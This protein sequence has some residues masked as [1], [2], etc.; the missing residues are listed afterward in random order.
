MPNFTATYL[1][2][3]TSQIFKTA[4][5]PATDASLVA[6]ELVTANLMGH[7]SHGVIRIPQYMGSIERGEIV[8][9]SI[10]KIEK[11]TSTT[12]VVDGGNNFGQ[13]SAFQALELGIKKAETHNLS[14]ILLHRCNHVGRLGAYPQQAAMQNFI[15][16]ATA[17]YVKVG[18][19][20]APFG[21]RQGRLGTNPIAYGIPT[22]DDPILADFATSVMAEGKIRVQRNKGGVLPD[23]AVLNSA[24]EVTQDPNQ[25]YGPP[26]GA[27]LPFGGPVGY[28]GF[29]LSL[30]VE[31]L[32]GALLGRLIDDPDLT[33]N[34]VC[35]ILLRP[36][37]FIELDAFRLLMGETQRYVKDTPAATGFNEV[38]LPGEIE[39]RTHKKRSVDGITLDEATWGQILEEAEKVGAEIPSV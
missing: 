21:G 1:E 7:D 17:N 18:H 9:G 19:S 28:K 13:V 37:A 29:A 6:K 10:P 35:F 8:P 15:C 5:A 30:L 36:D 33:G 27:I 31:I 2:T 39:F 32:G 20:V 34:G 16:I 26:R 38:I 11:E 23:Q 22:A 3:V 12:A 4:G 25:F 24:G 14:T